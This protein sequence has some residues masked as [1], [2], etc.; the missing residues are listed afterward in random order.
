MKELF[1][2]VQSVSAF[3]GGTI[4]YFLGEWDMLLYALL[5]FVIID[6]I[7]GVMCAVSDKNLSSAVGFKGIC[8]KG[9]I[10]IM[11]GVANVLDI[12]IL[13]NTCVLRSAVIFFYLSNEGISL[14]ENSAHLGLPIP[15][16]LKDILKQ[17][18]EKDGDSLSESSK[19]I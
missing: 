6:Y 5:V 11:V 12:T 2:Y 9:L 19:T 7:S 3:I 8:R 10:F 1:P 17:L 14:L 4:G 13:N 18:H 15:K 16:K